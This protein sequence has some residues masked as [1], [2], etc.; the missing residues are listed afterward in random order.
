MRLLAISTLVLALGACG[1]DDDAAIDA[2]PADA[3]ATASATVQIAP[4]TGQTVTGNAT[5]S[6]V[7]TAVSVTLTVANAAPGLHGVHIHATGDCGNN[8]MNAGDHWNP[9]AM[10]HGMPGMAPS[11]LG[12][13]G[14]MTVAADGTG[15]LT[16]SKAQWKIGDA[17]TG[18]VVGKALIVHEVDDDFGQPLGNAG[19]RI[20]CGVI[21]LAP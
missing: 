10:D 8:G 3:A 20:G 2:G 21:T 18:D 11:H 5:F 12:D 19:G 14:N 15:T 1:G 16:V 13:M 4:S 6:V 17:S 9:E 7:G